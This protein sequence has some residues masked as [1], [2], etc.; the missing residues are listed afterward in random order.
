MDSIIDPLFITLGLPWA[1]TS[2]ILANSSKATMLSTNILQ[3]RYP[4]K[5]ILLETL[6]VVTNFFK[7]L[8]WE[9][10]CSVL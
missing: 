9:K 7:K 4:I 3:G 10:V 8:W 2:I 1:F 6:V 5:E